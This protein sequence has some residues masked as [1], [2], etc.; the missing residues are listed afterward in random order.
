ML[1]SILLLCSLL[2]EFQTLKII[3]TSY[4]KLRGMAEWSDDANHKF[5]FKSVPFAKPPI[6]NLRF[7]PPQKLDHWDGILDASVYSAACMSNSTLTTQSYVNEDCLYINIFTSEKCLK[8][9]CS[10]IVYFHGGAYNTESAT[11]FS[12]RFIL[13]RYV[14]E[15]VIFVI[16]A[17]RLG[18]FGQLYFGPNA[19]LTENLFMFDAI[20]A[21]D[22]VHNEISNFGGDPEKVTIMGHSSGGTL[23]EALGFSSMVDPELKLFQQMIMLSSTGMF[24]FDDLVIDNSFT[25]VEKLGVTVKNADY[26]EE[27]NIFSVSMVRKKNETLG[28]PFMLLNGN[29]ADLKKNTSPRNAIFGTTE[30]EFF[31]VTEKYLY[32]TVTFLDYENPVA[33]A[34]N[35]DGR[36]MKNMET[37]ITGDSAA[38]F[39]STATC[40]AAMANAGADVFLFETRQSYSVHVSDMQYFIGNH[41]AHNRTIDIDILDSFYSKLLT[42]FTKHGKPSPGW[43]PVDPGRMNYL[44]LKVDSK[45]R[46]G[47]VML[48]GYHAK[49]VSFWVGEMTEFDQNVSKMRHSEGLPPERQDT[50]S[51]RQ[52]WNFIVYQNFDAKNQQKLV[53]STHF[54]INTTDQAI[55]FRTDI[56]ILYQWWF[57]L[58]IAVCAMTIG[59]VILSFKKSR[60]G[61]ITPLLS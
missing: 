60:N 30:H 20:L 15:D 32:I 29:I 23:V 45:A 37:M 26:C 16:P 14:H 9:K 31:D 4:G 38:I 58:I 55:I 7:A 24:G 48:E 61:E 12:D 57:Y 2:Y 53:D 25:I 33:V 35:Y 50:K 41:C 19:Y 52:Y 11:M 28:A 1:V 59:L 51:Q 46:S 40:A 54:I 13:D 39:V 10:V 18:V 43:D 8:S 36:L 6:G 47:P 56:S 17:V 27:I 42:N 3:N 21:L 22:F 49:D 44:E 5:T 34:R